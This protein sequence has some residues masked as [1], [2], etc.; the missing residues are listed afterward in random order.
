MTTEQGKRPV[1]AVNTVALSGRISSAPT[2]RELPSGDPLVTFRLAVP[3][4]P[5]A[6]TGRRYSDWFDCAVWGGRVLRTSQAWQVGDTVA[7]SG[8][9]RRRHYRAGDVTQTRVEVMVVTGRR[10]RRGPET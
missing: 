3:R 10:V 1:P 6:E 9:L 4:A 7:V 8:Q 2:L 5:E